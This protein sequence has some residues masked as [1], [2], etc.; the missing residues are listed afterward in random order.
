MQIHF[1]SDVFI[2]LFFF[3]L[4]HIVFS[5]F[6][7]T[8][9]AFYWVTFLENSSGI[10]PAGGGLLSVFN[11]WRQTNLDLCSLKMQ[12]RILKGNFM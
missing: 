7:T 12:L 8:S 5:S 4:H 9:E 3:R 11:I 10:C 1:V 2:F 6:V